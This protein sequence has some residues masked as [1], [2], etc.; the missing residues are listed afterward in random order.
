MKRKA[1]IEE[2]RMKTSDFD[3]MMRH[4]LSAPPLPAEQKPTA[5][6]GKRK[7]KTAKD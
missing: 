3:K 1:K 7:R 4:A 6:K 2:F 5:P